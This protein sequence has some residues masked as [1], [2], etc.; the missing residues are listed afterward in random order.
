MARE[1]VGNDVKGANRATDI[2][3]NDWAGAAKVLGPLQGV[4]SILGA[5]N[6]GVSVAQLGATIAV[7]NNSATTAFVALYPQTGAAP[8]GGANGIAL[9]PFAYTYVCMGANQFIIASAAT[10]FGYQV[11][12]ESYLTPN[13]KGYAPTPVN[14]VSPVSIA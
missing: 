6:A 5:L 4:L 1:K 3:Y 8:T 2:A 7:Y 11:I 9:P 13:S 14:G 10:V 12:D